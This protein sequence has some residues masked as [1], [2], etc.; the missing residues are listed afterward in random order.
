MSIKRGQRVL[1]AFGNGGQQTRIFTGLHILL[2][3]C[4]RF[5]GFSRYLILSRFHT[6]PFWLVTKYIRSLSRFG[7][8]K[9]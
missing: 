6:L 4:R 2:A 5:F 8:K 1:I 3:A 7:C 9:L